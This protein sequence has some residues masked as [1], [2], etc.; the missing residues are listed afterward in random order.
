MVCFIDRRNFDLLVFWNHV[1]LKIPACS[2][3]KLSDNRIA[4]TD[5]IDVEV[6][7]MDLLMDFQW[8]RCNMIKAVLTSLEMYIWGMSL[9][10]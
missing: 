5:K 4:V 10:R 3:R 1:V 7:M 2:S 9:G 6:D 8:L